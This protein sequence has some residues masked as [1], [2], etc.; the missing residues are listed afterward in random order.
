MMHAFEGIL[1][2]S[3]VLRFISGQLGVEFS[4]GSLKLADDC[5]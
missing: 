2:E 4:V 5:Y 3:S 1:F